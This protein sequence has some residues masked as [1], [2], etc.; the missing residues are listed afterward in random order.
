LV[1]ELAVGVPPAPAPGP[2]EPGQESLP[3]RE[4]QVPEQGPAPEPQEQQQAPEL[5]APELPEPE[6]ELP[7]PAG[8]VRRCYGRDRAVHR[9]LAG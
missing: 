2:Q 3:E 5:L 9:P 7:V 8:R 1:T 6:Q 4:R